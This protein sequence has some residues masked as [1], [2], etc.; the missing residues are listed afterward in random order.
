M[1][2]ILTSLLC[3]LWL[4]AGVAS[5]DDLSQR[6]DAL[7]KAHQS[8]RSDPER[9]A[10]HHHWEG[11]AKKLQQLID[12]RP[13][14]KLDARARYELGTTWRDVYDLSRVKADLALARDA[15]AELV[16][17]YPDDPLADDALYMLGDARSRLGD[18]KQARA[19]LLRVLRDYPDGNRIDE[20]QF[21]LDRLREAE[22]GE[23]PEKPVKADE[24]AARTAE[25]PATADERAA[26]TAEKPATADERAARTAEKPATADERAARSG[27]RSAATGEKAARTAERPQTADDREWQGGDQAAEISAIKVWTNPDY[28]RLVLHLTGRAA[29][30]D[31]FRKGH[32][33]RGLSHIVLELPATTVADT[34]HETLT[35]KGELLEVPVSGGL[36]DGLT[37]QPRSGGGIKLE[38]AAARLRSYH[39]S[40]FTGP[41]RILIDLFGEVGPPEDA[42]ELE[43]LV[44]NLPAKSKNGRKAVSRTPRY[45]VVVDAGHG[46]DDPGATGPK[47]THEKD[48]TLAIALK[49]QKKLS[50]LPGVRVI[51]TRDTDVFVPLDE[52]TAIANRNKADLFI[53]IHC[54]AS[55]VATNRGL[56]TY[57]LDTASDEAA[58]RLAA[59]EN[60]TLKNRGSDLAFILEDL[61]I[62]GNVRYSSR[63]A[64]AVHDSV[65][66][67]LRKKYPPKSVRDLGVKTALFYVLFGAQMPSIL[68][69][70][71]F[72]SNE[73]EETR[74][75]G[76]AFQ[77]QIAESIRD[78]VKR[79]QRETLALSRVDEPK[80]E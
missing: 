53:S 64:R 69:E 15:F 46:G 76:E 3:C 71:A 24:R 30:R 39:V 25:K 31:T 52:R 4:W 42:D 6:Y 18:V 72:I 56:E 80:G 5:A 12:A 75:N 45:T 8:L 78:G 19:D 29:W 58:G 27:E 26:R 74:L 22:K 9:R 23:K 51:M 79:Y 37:V 28:T 32:D 73:L 70:T 50:T 2:R 1:S 60:A 21:L 59:R 40:A 17:R 66:E 36:L 34:L 43:T 63:L 7:R 65:L 54:N 33:D 44:L 41:N 47:G 68:V 20:A 16:K 38:L 77:G 57:Y 55:P 10:F 48:L 35:A 61:V 62:E 67:R 13:P 14:A 11:L 49:V